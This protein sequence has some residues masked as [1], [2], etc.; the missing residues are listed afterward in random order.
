[1]PDRY[2]E[3]TFLYLLCVSLVLHLGVFAVLHFLPPDPQKPAKEP[4]FID[5]QQMPEPKP[6]KQIIRNKPAQ[7]LKEKRAAKKNEPEDKQKQEIIKNNKNYITLPKGE[8]TQPEP[9]LRTNERHPPE[10]ESGQSVSSLLKPKKKQDK[11]R[12]QEDLLIKKELSKDIENRIKNKLKKDNKAGGFGG[13]DDIDSSLLSFGRRVLEE[14]NN[15]LKY[16]PQAKQLGLE[17][18]GTVDVTYNRKGE[19]VE[20]VITKSIHKLFDEAVIDA[21]NK[22]VV[23]PF[24]KAYKSDTVTLPLVYFFQLPPQGQR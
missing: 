2:I 12:F 7:A 8:Q 19:V 20:I 15:H 1:M 23:G 22:A 21:F 13:I 10:V 16:P 11:T 9:R 4:V 17:G 18:I 14:A 6:P 24:P 3:K 5:L